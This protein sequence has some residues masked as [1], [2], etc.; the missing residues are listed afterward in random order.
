M[1]EQADLVAILDLLGPHM[2]LQLDDVAMARCF[3]VDNSAD[4]FDAAVVFAQ[5]QHCEFTFEPNTGWGRFGC[6][7][8]KEGE[9]DA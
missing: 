6:A 7:Q 9:E 8:Y 4:A 2:W 5:Q 1:T 3:G